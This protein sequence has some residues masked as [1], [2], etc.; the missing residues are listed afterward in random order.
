MT[1]YMITGFLKQHLR[2]AIKFNA[3]EDRGNL[4][5][6]FDMIVEEE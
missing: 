4:V 1:F 2:A 5:K 3:S 6:F